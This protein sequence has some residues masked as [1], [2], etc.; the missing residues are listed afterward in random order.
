V[1]AH[2]LLPFPTDGGDSIERDLVEIDAA[3]AL[4]FRGIATRVRLVGLIGPEAAAAIG[5]AHAQL[6]NVGFSLERNPDGG[7]T[8]T[9]GPRC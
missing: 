4:V 3:I 9:L 5:L 2:T 1:D 6:A 8:V 7:A